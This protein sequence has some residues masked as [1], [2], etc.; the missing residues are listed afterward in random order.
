MHADWPPVKEEPAQDK[1]DEQQL[2]IS[3]ALFYIDNLFGLWNLLL[4]DVLLLK[5]LATNFQCSL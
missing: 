1:L 2:L 3:K 5:I 4:T